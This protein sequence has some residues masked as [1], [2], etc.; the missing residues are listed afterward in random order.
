MKMS[1]FDYTDGMLFNL[2]EKTD[3]LKA[4]YFND[5]YNTL[6]ETFDKMYA[7]IEA[8]RN[9]VKEQIYK[10]QQEDKR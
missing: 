8:S 7:N 2:Q 1:I 6:Q 3:E 5:M 4:V 9:E 10:A